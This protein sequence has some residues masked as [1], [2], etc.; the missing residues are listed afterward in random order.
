MSKQGSLVSWGRRMALGE[1][2]R[3]RAPVLR[4]M[5]AD[6]EGRGIRVQVA[7][8][9]AL[10]GIVGGAEIEAILA[11]YIVGSESGWERITDDRGL[12]W[13]M[14]HATPAQKAQAFLIAR[15][16]AE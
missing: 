7:Y 13:R 3:N 15:G 4:R 16:E 9:E 2:L 12:V 1:M 10:A 11:N 6:I 5:Q 8:I 14:L